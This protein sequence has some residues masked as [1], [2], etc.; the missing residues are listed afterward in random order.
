[1]LTLC[2]RMSRLRGHCK[3]SKDG[4]ECKGL[5]FAYNT[6]EIRANVNDRL[7]TRIGSSILRYMRDGQLDRETSVRPIDS[8]WQWPSVYFNIGL[9]PL[10]RP[11]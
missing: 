2:T 5:N 7:E 9:L 10:S 1:M 8:K 3:P 6:I 11:R 4:S